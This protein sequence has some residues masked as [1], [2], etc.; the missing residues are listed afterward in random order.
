M[1]GGPGAGPERGAVARPSNFGHVAQQ[2]PPARGVA[3]LQGDQHGLDGRSEPIP[4]SANLDGSNRSSVST[5]GRPSAGGARAG[6]SRGVEGRPQRTQA[7]Q[8]ARSAYRWRLRGGRLASERRWREAI[9]ALQAASSLMPEHPGFHLFLA[10][11]RERQKN[12]RAA[13]ALRA[14]RRR[15]S[16]GP[17]V[18]CSMWSLAA[19][20][21]GSR[22]RPE[23]L[24]K[25]HRNRFDIRPCLPRTG[26]QPGLSR[27]TR[28]GGGDSGEL[29]APRAG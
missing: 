12:D 20:R 10:G 29:R 15:C 18:S 16:A 14:R 6:L 13:R 4:R 7:P 22:C 5:P 11:L 8:P 24:R 23:V 1:G 26:A 2:I 9:E 25:S 19:G 27:A 21:R 28:E 3:A 17:P